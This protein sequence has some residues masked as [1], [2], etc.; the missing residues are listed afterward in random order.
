MLTCS[1]ISAW[2]YQKGEGVPQDLGIASEIF[3]ER[4]L[5]KDTLRTV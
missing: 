1:M 4:R 2:L 3:I 5:T